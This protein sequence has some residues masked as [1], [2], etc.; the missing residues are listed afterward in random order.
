M[1]NFGYTEAV[2][3]LVV[4]SNFRCM[5]NVGYT[6]AVQGLVVPSAGAANQQLGGFIRNG[7]FLLI[8]ICGF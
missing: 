2:Q 8:F 3:G 1:N 6:E 4:A 5:N 7:R